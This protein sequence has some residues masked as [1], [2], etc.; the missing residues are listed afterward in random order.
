MNRWRDIRIVAMRE[1]VERSRSTVFRVA[2]IGMAALVAGGIVLLSL[3]GGPTE[4]I[5]IGLGGTT[6]E[7]IE[8]D[9]VAVGSAL[10]EEVMVIAYESVA[11]ATDA[12]REGTVDVALVE[13]STIVSKSGPS[14]SETVI[15]STAVNVAAR[16]VVGESLGLS[17]DQITAIVQPVNLESVEL[18]ESDPDEDAKSL[19]AYAGGLLLF[20]T[21]MMFGQF[22]AYGIV[23]EKQNRVVEVLLSRIDSTSL[24]TGKVIGIGLLGLMQV[25][26]IVGAAVIAISVVPTDGLAEVDLSVIGIGA[27]LSLLVWYV[28]GFLMFSF[29][30]A[31]F[32]ATVSRLEDLQ[33]VAFVPVI[34]IVPA[35]LIV[36][37]SLGGNITALTRIA[38]FVPF[39]AP[40]VMPLRIV[41]GDAQAWEVAL[42]ISIVL[43][44]IWLIVRFASRVYRGA[45]LRTGAKVKLS[46]A[47]RGDGV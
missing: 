23:E 10:D 15:L 44:T 27:Y 22:V 9:I 5:S 20:V 6:I 18:D 28:L 47:Y 2:M 46:E 11:D 34:L 36:T 1:I 31:A 13:S 29:V 24:L 43:V 17:N 30:Y 37:L 38:S 33:S 8:A 19:V 14:T 21:I 45:A 32:G 12:V 40:I 42:S 35:Y 16:R 26:V 4:A 41:S 39:W 7:G 25:A 3:L